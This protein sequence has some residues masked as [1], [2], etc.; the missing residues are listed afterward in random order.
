MFGYLATSGTS[1]R[2]QR[3]CVPSETP[4]HAIPLPNRLQYTG[5]RELDLQ[6]CGYV[7]FFHNVIKPV[8]NPFTTDF[9]V[10]LTTYATILY[11]EAARHG[12]SRVLALPV[13]VGLLY[14]IYSIA[15]IYPLYWLAFIWTGA[16]SLHKRP[17][18]EH[19]KIDQAHAEGILFSIFVGFLVPTACMFIMD[20]PYV[21]AI[22]QVFP[23]LMTISQLAHRLFRPSSRYPYSGYPTVRASYIL[24]F[25]LA[26]SYHIGIAWP[27]FK[28]TA[29]LKH[30]FAP[31]IT[32]NSEMMTLEL[33]V[34]EFL[35]LDAAFS[36][37]TIVLA[38]LWFARNFKE[39][40]LLVGWYVVAIVLVGP[41]AAVAGVFLWRES[42]LN[43]QR[44][45]AVELQDFKSS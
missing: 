17:G 5:I 23:L 45:V 35:K 22:W 10:T 39:I 15:V 31:T 34:L 8:N 37:A 18:G 7:V 11:F 43:A 2:I 14:Q 38:S 4:L 40:L 25:V 1:V 9:L 21:T 27:K 30:L 24:L 42:L 12:R 6:L 36:T 41:G 33:G 13:I 28:D 19:T 26:S 44:L 20:D 16:A 3:H 29:L 32:P